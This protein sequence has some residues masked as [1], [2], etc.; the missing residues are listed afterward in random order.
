M[1]FTALVLTLAG[2]GCIRRIHSDVTVTYV[3]DG[4]ELGHLAILPVTG[5]AGLEGVRRSTADSLLAAIAT[6]RPELT[7]VGAN[8]SARLIN[9]QG[10][11][12]G[13]ADLL[14]N[15]DRTGVLDREALELLFHV[16]DTDYVMHI[17]VEL[18][19]DGA[20]RDLTLFAQLWHP[21]EGI[22]WEAS[23]AASY[24]SSGLVTVDGPLLEALS[25]T[26]RK[27]VENL[28]R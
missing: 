9:G 13:Y 14:H 18:F 8:E 20:A 24:L 10:V 11:A 16:L 2:S 15:Y 1:W 27:L 28:P 17:E 26:A 7:L 6:L 4:I 19:Q 3:T 23:S 5:G 22:V 21:A 12:G 25:A